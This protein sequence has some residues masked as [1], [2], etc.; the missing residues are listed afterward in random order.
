M[1]VI[2]INLILLIYVSSCHSNQETINLIEQENQDVDT[3]NTIINNQEEELEELIG[4]E[5]TRRNGVM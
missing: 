3:A 5:H 1:K 4:I 2:L